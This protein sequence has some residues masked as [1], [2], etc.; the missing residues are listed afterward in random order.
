[1]LFLVPIESY[2]LRYTA[3][4]NRW[5]PADLERLKVPYQVIAPVRASQRLQNARADVLDVYGT[6]LAKYSQLQRVVRL[7]REGGITHGDVLFF[8]T[9]WFSGID[10][11]Q[12][13]RQATRCDL[14]IVGVLHAGSYDPW[15]FRTRLGMRPWARHLEAGWLRFVDRVFFG[16]GFHRDMVQRALKLDGDRLFVTRLPFRT[17]EVVE[18]RGR[19]PKRPWIAFP[20]RLVPEKDPAVVHRLRSAL[21]EYKTL[22]TR[23][24][25]RTKARYYDLLAQCRVTVS[26]SR[27]ETFGYAMLEAAA[28]GSVPIVP[29]RLSYREMYPEE[30]RFKTDR[31]L[32][33]KVRFHVE[34]WSDPRPRV[35]KLLGECDE[36]AAAMIRLAVEAVNVPPAI[37]LE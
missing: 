15:D 33:E 10:S 6:H 25:C 5:F 29:D 26:N 22:I 8:H 12:Y 9:L 23:E 19:S 35:E 30:W 28:L 16:S 31:E 21:P 13:I 17:A 7:L 11:I 2:D 3:Q 37:R 24:L 18:G 27:Q 34:N 32:V 20:H 36:A 4:W 1:M 14:R